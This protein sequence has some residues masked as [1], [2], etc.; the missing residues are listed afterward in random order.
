MAKIKDSIPFQIK[1]FQRFK[2]V[3]WEKCEI[4]KKYFQFYSN[5]FLKKLLLRFVLNEIKISKWL[6]NTTLTIQELK[7]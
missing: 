6:K 2:M 5:I 1:K 4:I 7:T 3:L